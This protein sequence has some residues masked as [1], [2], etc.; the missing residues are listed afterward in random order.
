MTLNQTFTKRFLLSLLLLIAVAPLQFGFLDFVP[1][2]LQ[3]LVILWIA[4]VF[5]CIP[6]TWAVLAYLVLA[7]LGVPVLSNFRGGWECFVGPTA[8]FLIGFPIVTFFIGKYRRFV[9]MRVHW[10]FLAFLAGHVA[11]LIFGYIGLAA[12][13]LSFS[14]IMAEYYQ[15]IPG[16]LI[17]SIAGA[18][19]VRMEFWVREMGK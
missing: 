1:I 3:S 10:L 11:L 12:H 15:L 9:S 6:A 5:G 4:F 7:A 18:T 19:L 13:K 16:T 8:G 14:E 17:K 2:S